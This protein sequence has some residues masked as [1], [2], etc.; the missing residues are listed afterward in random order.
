M[1]FEPF[2]RHLLLEP[3]LEKKKEEKQSTILLPEDYSIAKRHEVYEVVA[4]AQ[5]CIQLATSDVGK[6]I[7]VD[8]TMVEEIDVNGDVFYL[9]LENHIY[10][11]INLEE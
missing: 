6:T 1:K 11:V 3:I 5:D 2:N 7:V 9:L 10:G 4:V 8:N